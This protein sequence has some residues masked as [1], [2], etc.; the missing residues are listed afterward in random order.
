MPLYS[1]EMNFSHIFKKFLIDDGLSICDYTIFPFEEL[2]DK[3][4]EFA[5]NLRKTVISRR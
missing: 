5:K 2:D 1:V 4:Y 3:T